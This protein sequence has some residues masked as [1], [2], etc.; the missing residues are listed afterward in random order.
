MASINDTFLIVFI[1]KNFS[2]DAHEL[3]RCVLFVSFVVIEIL[4][5]SFDFPLLIRS[6]IIELFKAY[7]FGTSR[8]EPVRF[9]DS[10]AGDTV[11]AEAAV[12]LLGEIQISFVYIR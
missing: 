7:V 12:A 6:L 2:R 10:T 3:S 1:V 9:Q 8:D 5:S 4:L 11:A